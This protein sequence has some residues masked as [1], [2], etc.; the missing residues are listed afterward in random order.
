[1]KK[2]LAAKCIY[3]VHHIAHNR[4][5]NPNQNIQLN[6]TTKVQKNL[7]TVEPWQTV[8]TESKQ[9][10]N[11]KENSDRSQFKCQNSDRSQFKCQNSDRSQFKCQNSDRSQFKCQNRDI[12][13]ISWHMVMQSNTLHTQWIPVVL[14]PAAPYQN[15]PI[16]I[17]I[18]TDAK[19]ITNSI[20]VSEQ[21]Y[22]WTPA[23]CL[24]SFHLYTFR[25]WVSA[26]R[27]G[28][29]CFLSLA[30][31]QQVYVFNVL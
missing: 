11:K 27:N 12:S 22:C 28:V 10:K 30:S 13:P 5:Q 6:N 1:M 25:M 3:Q 29:L 24:T 23:S 15:P 8:A 17:H 14:A 18:Y 7:P 9:H 20:I 21:A 31:I 16:H 2:I 4:H 19:Q 26:I